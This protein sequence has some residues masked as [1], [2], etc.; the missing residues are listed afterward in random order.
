[1]KYEKMEWGTMEAVVNMLGGMEGVSALLA[2]KLVITKVVEA[3]E[4]LLTF[5]G[6]V[7]IPATTTKFIAREKFVQ[8]TSRTAKVKISFLGSNFTSWFLDK[9]EDPIGES[10]MGYYKLIKRS[11]DAPILKELGGQEKAMTFIATIFALMELQS[12]G[13]EGALLTNGYVN[14]FY[15]PD[16]SGVLRAVHVRWHGVDWDVRAHSVANP[17]R[18]H[19]GYQVFSRNP[20]ST[21][22]V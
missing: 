16:S 1:M 17:V 6:T 3:V 10:I 11:V 14:I 4:T 13:E 18:W 12:N 22:A 2:G 19:V 21:Q 20:L 8:D 5:L 9:I 15:V 7:T